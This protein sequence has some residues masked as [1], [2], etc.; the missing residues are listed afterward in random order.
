M[1]TVLNNMIAKHYSLWKS[2]A[3]GLMKS[4][5]AGEELLAEVMCYLL[6]RHRDTLERLAQEDKLLWYVNRSIYN[7]ATDK[8]SRYHMLHT[9]YNTNWD[10]DITQIPEREAPWLGSRID[11]EYLDAYISLMPEI[12]KTIIRIYMMADFDYKDVSRHTKIPVK[13]LYKLVENAINKL[14]ANAHA[15]DTE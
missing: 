10:A 12:D 5:D 1:S 14:K 15:K 9:R 4:Q 3:V 11:N 8:S 6:D 2:H 7:M 13:T